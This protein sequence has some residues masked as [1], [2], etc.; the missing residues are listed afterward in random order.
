M[1]PF[2]QDRIEDYL[3]D[4]LS[5]EDRERFE[6]LLAEDADAAEVIQAFQQT[7][8]LFEAIRAPREEIPV[9]T[10][11]FYARLRQTI[12]EE[13][14][15]PFWAAF[16]QP[17]LLKRV[18]FVALMWMFALGSLTLLTDNTPQHNTKL[19]DMILKAQ[20]P[21]QYHVRMGADLRQNRDSMLVVMFAPDQE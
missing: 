10:A 8:F 4:R 21:E 6:A 7:A 5:P 12:D 2:L 20:P 1:E 11:G 18:A 16:L 13:N 14:Q 17:L 3:T 15:V 19:A 9:P